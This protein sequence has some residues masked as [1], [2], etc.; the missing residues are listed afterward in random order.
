LESGYRGLCRDVCRLDFRLRRGELF[1]PMQADSPREPVAGG[2]RP[3]DPPA[4]VV[5]AGD[6][7]RPFCRL[8]GSKLAISVD[9]TVARYALP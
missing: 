2:L 5:S 8:L 4:A 3:P 9:V 7:E 1:R 6:V